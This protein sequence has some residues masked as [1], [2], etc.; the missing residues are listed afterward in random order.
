MIRSRWNKHE[1]KD[2][3]KKEP[4]EPCQTGGF[5]ICGMLIFAAVIG[6]FEEQKTGPDIVFSNQGA[7]TP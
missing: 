7:K 4:Q 6:A 3:L 5:F 1:A 2:R